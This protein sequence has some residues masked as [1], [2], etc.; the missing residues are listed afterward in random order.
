MTTFFESEDD[1]LVLNI[2]GAHYE[3]NVSDVSNFPD[4]VLGDPLK[5]IRYLVPGK[6]DYFFPRHASSFESILYY[7]INDGVLIKSETI[8]AMIFYEEIRFFQLNDKLVQRFYNDYLSSY[9]Q[10]PMK[11]DSRWKKIFSHSS[12]IMKTFSAVFNALAIYSLCVETMSVYR[13]VHHTMWIVTH[14]SK[15]STCSDMNIRPYQFIPSFNSENTTLEMICIAWFY[16]ELFTRTLITPSLFQLIFDPNFVL[17]I[18]CI[19]PTILSQIF[20]QIYERNGNP[21]KINETQLFDYLTCLKLFRLFR[22]TRHV[23]CLITLLKVLYINL[24]DVLMLTILIIFGVF[25]FGLTQFV[26]EQMYEE[27]EMKNIG[28]ALWHG[29]TVI[30]T[31]GYSDLAE[32]Q[33]LSY[34]FAIVGVWYGSISM[35]II[36]PNVTQSF[37]VFHNIKRRRFMIKYKIN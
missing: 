18:L 7:Y 19:L 22:L 28:E 17:D 25:Y 26:L 23:Q 13:S 31:I 33:F 11:A 27:N 1:R 36:L 30:I 34:I 24:K 20:Y 37:N 16:F 14:P 6:T 10:I 35:A 8:P 29:F 9:E 3:I 15:P 4:T 21:T 32:H 2:S 12:N 5:R